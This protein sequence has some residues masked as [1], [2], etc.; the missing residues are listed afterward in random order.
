[1]KISDPFISS[2]IL[3]AHLKDLKNYV[4]NNEIDNIKNLLKKLVESY[5][6]NS[7]VV[8]QIYFHDKKYNE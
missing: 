3:Q 8:D 5:E 7:E 4:E 6:T 1:M 2:D